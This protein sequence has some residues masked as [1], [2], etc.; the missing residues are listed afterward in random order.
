MVGKDISSF[1]CYLRSKRRGGV[2]TN[3]MTV[4]AADDNS[5]GLP[6]LFLQ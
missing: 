6:S 1:G 4:A 3:M 5:D 2:V